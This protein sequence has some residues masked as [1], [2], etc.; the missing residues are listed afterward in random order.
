ML[1]EAQ[2]QPQPGRYD[3]AVAADGAMRPVWGTIARA[4]HDMR[5]IDLLDQQ[6]QA[7]RLLDA[8]GAGH[9]VHEL[10]PD[11]AHP[12]Q[13]TTVDSRPWRL[14]PLP[15]ILGHDEFRQLAR[16]AVQRV[17]M[18]EAL[19]AD[20]YGERRLVRTG[21]LPPDVLFSVGSLRTTVASHAP[22]R[23]LSHYA[24]DLVRVADGTWRVVQDAT[25]APAGAGYAM[26]N[27]S[28]VARVM[29]DAM[30]SAG[31][32]PI[33]TFAAVMRRALAAQAPAGRKSPRTVVLTGGPAHPTY[34]EHSYLAVQ[35]GFHLAEGGDLVVRKNRVWLRALDG[36]EPV[37]VIY[38]RVEAVR[39]CPASRGRRSRVG[40]RSRTRSARASPRNPRSRRSSAT[41]RARCWARRSSC[42]RCRPT[43]RSRRRRACRRGR[44]ARSCRAPS[45]CVSIWR[46]PRTG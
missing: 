22:S 23:W 39:A 43:T 32:A 13:P 7:D 30:R 14:D 40:C 25:D 5:P 1:N 37:D 27:R 9:L 45:F 29:P 42:R 35:M 28:V 3:E 20:L 4:L 19:L 11:D 33:N 41:P 31:V 18:F 15:L 46:S 17:R 44:R 24:V 2:Y 12:D 26:M 38:R 6:R 8:E 10:L 34:V 21:V 16:A 36:V